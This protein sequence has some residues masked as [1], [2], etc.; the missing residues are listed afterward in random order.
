MIYCNYHHLGD[1][2]QQIKEDKGIAWIVTPVWKNDWLQDIMD[3]LMEKPLIIPTTAI[4]HISLDTGKSFR[5]P[6]WH[7]F[8][9]KVNTMGYRI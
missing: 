9:C 5:K 1:H 8:V 4:T 6:M 7:T 3:H 2:L